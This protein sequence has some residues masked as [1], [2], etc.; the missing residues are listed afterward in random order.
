[1][2]TVVAVRSIGSEVLHFLTPIT[3]VGIAV[4]VVGVIDCI[5]ISEACGAVGVQKAEVVGVDTLVD[6][7]GDNALS[8]IGLFES[9]RA[10]MHLIKADRLTAQIHMGMGLAGNL[11]CMYRRLL[12]KHLGGIDRHHAQSYITSA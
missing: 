9:G 5:E 8:P 11:H 12:S 2:G 7:S 6:N 3:V 4:H 10:G 1:M